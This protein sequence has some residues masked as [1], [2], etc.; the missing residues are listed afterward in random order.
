MGIFEVASADAGMEET[1]RDTAILVDCTGV[2][3]II[4]SQGW[5][6]EGLQSHYGARTVYQVRRDAGRVRV[7]GRSGS[8]TC[9]L[10]TETPAAKAVRLLERPGA[11]AL[12]HRWA[13]ANPYLLA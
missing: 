1:A 12:A 10:E 3:R 2:L 8:Q 11:A 4:D 6:M 13:S 9:L 5:S 7:E